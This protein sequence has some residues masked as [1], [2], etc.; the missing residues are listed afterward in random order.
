MESI[1]TYQAL[2]YGNNL[3]L[4]NVYGFVW[5]GFHSYIFSQIIRQKLIKKLVL[6]TCCAFLLACMVYYIFKGL[7]AWHGLIQAIGSMLLVVFCLIY[8]VELFTRPNM[9]PLL[10][11]PSF[12][13]CLATLYLYGGSSVLIGFNSYLSTASQKMIGL[14]RTVLILT[15]CSYYLLL[16]V[17]FL[18]RLNFKNAG[19]KT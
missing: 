6:Y 9:G 13:I 16:S 3:L 4:Y 2:R 12:W 18:C 1:A 7:H 8:I 17:A 10:R 15:N 11:E 14:L 19:Q 5:F